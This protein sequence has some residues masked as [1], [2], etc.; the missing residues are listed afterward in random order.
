M[1]SEGYPRRTLH[2]PHSDTFGK[3]IHYMDHNDRA[4]LSYEKAKAIGLSYGASTLPCRIGVRT[5]LNRRIGIRSL[6]LVID[7]SV[8]DVLSLTPKFWQLH[9]DP[10]VLLDGGAITLLT[11]QYNLCAGTIARYTGRRPE[12]IPLVEDLLQY[13]KQYVVLPFRGTLSSHVPWH[14]IVSVVNT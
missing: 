9:S 7:M 2:L 14:I 8:D 3:P 10:A 12:L 5:L 13:R 4:H 1:S 6:L 11:I